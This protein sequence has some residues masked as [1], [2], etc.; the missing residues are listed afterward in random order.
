MLYLKSFKY[1]QVEFFVGNY[2]YSEG[3]EGFISSFQKT[4]YMNLTYI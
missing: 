2:W 1:K 3:G 4:N